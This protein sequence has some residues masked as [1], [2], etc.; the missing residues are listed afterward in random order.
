MLEF[1]DEEPITKIGLIILVLSP[2]GIVMIGALVV[3]GLVIGPF[4]A[5]TDAESFGGIWKALLGNMLFTLL[6]AAYCALNILF[7]FYLSTSLFGL[8]K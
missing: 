1:F 3:V 6:C 4:A 5:I 7:W 8:T 2:M